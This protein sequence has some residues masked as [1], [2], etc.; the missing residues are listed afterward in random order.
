MMPDFAAINPYYTLSG[1]MVGMLV[2]LTG[3]GGGSL[4]TPLLVMV[5]GIHPVTAVGTDLLYAAFTKTV[6]TAVHGARRSVDWRVVRLLA[7]GSMPATILTTLVLWL[8]GAQHGP[9][10]KVI[11]VVLGIAVLITA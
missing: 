3:V 7:T 5:F 8:L 11:T 4:M 1:L 9:P 2:G 10:S 6:G